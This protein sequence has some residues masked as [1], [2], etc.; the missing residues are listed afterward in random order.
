MQLSEAFRF[1]SAWN[2]LYRE[3]VVHNYKKN[4]QYLSTTTVKKE[5]DKKKEERR[6]VV[7]NLNKMVIVVPPYDITPASAI[8]THSTKINT[9]SS[10][11][12]HIRGEKTKKM[13][14]TA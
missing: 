1:P 2:Y 10:I 9:N 12:N 14:D 4:L 13:L 5:E 7:W 8:I 3:G 11:N 6:G